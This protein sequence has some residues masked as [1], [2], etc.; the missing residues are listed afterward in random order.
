M[1]GQDALTEAE[2]REILLRL[3]ELEF[4]RQR[5]ALQQDYMT[6]EHEQDQREADLSRRELA[7]EKQATALAQKESQLWKDQAETWEASYRSVTQKG[8]VGYT[9]CKI[10]TLGLARCQ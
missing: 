4:A 2:R 6:K 10:F 5:I 1:W 3:G 9:F 7:A 8:G